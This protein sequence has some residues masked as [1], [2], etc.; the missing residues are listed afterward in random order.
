MRGLLIVKPD[1]PLVPIDASYTNSAL[2]TDTPLIAST[3][4][5]FGGLRTYYVLAYAQGANGEVK[6]RPLDAGASQL[7]IRAQ[8]SQ[9]SD[10]TCRRPAWHAGRGAWRDLRPRK[11]GN[12]GGTRQAAT[13]RHA[14]TAG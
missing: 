5:D 1:S 8:D 11:C 10:T 7:T 6:F 12:C 13:R 9:P 4:S 2:G 14:G 3:Y